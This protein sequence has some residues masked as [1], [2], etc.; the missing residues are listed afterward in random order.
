MQVTSLEA[1]PVARCRRVFAHAH[2]YHINSI[3][4]NRSVISDVE[5]YLFTGI[6]FALFLY[7]S[8]PV[9]LM[10]GF[11]CSRAENRLN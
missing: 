10:F 1:N 11:P 3:S 8:L 5:F 2:D 7:A 4:N 6:P 9:F